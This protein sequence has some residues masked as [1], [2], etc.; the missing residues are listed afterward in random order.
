MKACVLTALLLAPASAIAADSLTSLHPEA[1]IPDNAT[2]LA[3]PGDYADLF[4]RAQEKLHQYGFDPGP[5]NGD[6]NAKTQAALAQFQIARSL[7]ASGMLDDTT[8]AALG[9]D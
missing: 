7:P 9:V 8:R 4:T 5:V 3:S 2:E 6:F 1:A